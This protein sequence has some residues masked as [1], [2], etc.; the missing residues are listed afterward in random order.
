[1][2]FSISCFCS[3][4]TVEIGGG[5]W[6]LTRQDSTVVALRLELFGFGWLRLDSRLPQFFFHFLVSCVICVQGSWVF[7]IQEKTKRLPVF[8]PC[9]ARFPHIHIIHGYL[10]YIGISLTTALF[11]LGGII[12]FFVA[13]DSLDALESILLLV[14]EALVY[15]LEYL[16]LDLACKAKLLRRLG[17]GA[18]R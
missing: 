17:D 14:L 10:I 15:L 8:G 3:Y 5:L 16:M 7:F 1:M 18:W 4:V 12:T 11:L 2:S 6:L 13:M 9:I